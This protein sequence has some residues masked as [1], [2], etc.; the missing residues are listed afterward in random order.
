MDRCYIYS[1][2]HLTGYKAV[3]IEEIKNFRQLGSITAGH[4]EYGHVPGVETTTGPFRAGH[5]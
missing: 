1:L 2:L 4:P 3:D 5:I